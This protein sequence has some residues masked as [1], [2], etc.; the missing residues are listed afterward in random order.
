MLSKHILIAYIVIF[1]SSFSYAEEPN[2]TENAAMNNKRLE[3]I[4]KNLD[5]DFKGSNGHWQFQVNSATLT[6]L[7]D[8][9]H[10]RMRIIIPILE[11]DQLSKDELYR[12][13]QANFDSA[14]DARYAVAKGLLWS[15]YIH[16]LASLTDEQFLLGVGQTV[17]LV[18]T[19]GGSYSS[20]LLNF[21]GGDSQ[22]LR[23]RELIDEI[24]QKGQAI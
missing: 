13:M 19:F 8:E 3:A 6:V 4:I 15:T 17:N 20:G 1:L 5:E 21:S 11:S 23:E 9:S 10:D 16:P 7:T 12:I 2:T 14:L 24:L 22:G 18:S